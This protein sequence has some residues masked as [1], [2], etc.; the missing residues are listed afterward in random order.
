MKTKPAPAYGVRAWSEEG[1]LLALPDRGYYTADGAGADTGA[2]AAEAAA[3]EAEIV[4]ALL[5]LRM[6]AL[7]VLH[8]DVEDYVTYDSLPSFLPGAPA[9]AAAHL[10]HRQHGQR[11]HHGHQ[12]AHHQTDERFAPLYA[13]ACGH[14]DGR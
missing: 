3:L 5:R 6:N 12:Q 10:E 11:H 4:P 2:I 1:T 14:S 8:S 9:V 7:V 13:K